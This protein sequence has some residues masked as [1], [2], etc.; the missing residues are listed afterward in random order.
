M[1]DFD[2]ILSMELK[3]E[4]ADR[5]FGFR[6]MIE[7]DIKGYNEEL[8]ITFTHLEQTIGLDL[9]RLYILL[10]DNDIIKQFFK[11]TGFTDEQFLDPY[12]LESRTLRKR[13]FYGCIK[14]GFTKRGR[15]TNLFLHIYAELEHY[16]ESYHYTLQK[17]IQEQETIDEEI[18][19]FYRNNDLSAILGFFRNIDSGA[20][21]TQG[22]GFGDMDLSENSPAG[23]ALAEKMRVSP[24]R[25]V[26]ET[27]PFLP[28]LKP[29]KKIKKPLIQ[30]IHSAFERQGM[31]DITS[32]FS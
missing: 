19:L 27:L 9:I 14:K 3:K 17:L 13:L 7:E 20:P 2:Q 12:F 6:K 24:P 15:F 8:N 31:P 25:P 29:L 26:D 4:V 22:G 5:Y 28:P 1:H 18:K 10:R 16:L 32:C 11:L 30:L 21:L 23:G